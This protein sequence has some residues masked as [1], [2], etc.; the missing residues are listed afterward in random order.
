[1][2][3]RVR[4]LPA[5]FEPEPSDYLIQ[6][7]DHLQRQLGDLAE[8]APAQPVSSLDATGVDAILLADLSGAAYGRAA[9]LVACELPI[10]I[11][12]SEFATVS[13]WDWEIRDYLAHRGVTTIAPDSVQEARL[14]LS[15]LAAKRDLNGGVFL[16]YLDDLGAGMQPDIFK[17]FFW[18][19]DECVE[20]LK[21]QFGLNVIRKSYRGLIAQAQEIPAE[22]VAA[23]AAQVRL[24][25]Q[26]NLSDSQ[27]ED[28]MRIYLALERD[29]TST[30]RV[31]AAGINCLNESESA[32]ST[33]C[34][35]FDLL[36]ERHGIIWGCESDLMSMFTAYVVDKVTD[37]AFAMTN[38]YPFAIGEAALK[39][40]GIPGFPQVAGEP[41]DHIL[42][43]HCGYFGIVPK[44]RACQWSCE[45]PVL[46]IVNRNS[47][48]IDAR[49]QTGQATLVKARGDARR[50]T[51]KRADF[52]DYVQYPG[53]DCRNGGVLRVDD[54]VGYVEKLPSH[55]AIVA[56]G[57]L[58][59]RL[60]L[61]GA[62]MGL[63]I[64][65]L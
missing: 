40:E 53:S 17:R 33:P 62:V 64:E 24:E 28:A 55:H 44:C 20:T 16:A 26:P 21:E 38:L 48:A 14:L 22:R 29:V 1:M 11:I 52:V 42:V 37:A 10:M 59:R 54:G 25:R 31:L 12:T 43:A 9:E 15:G 35:A 61:V 23:A 18:Y 3:E 45:P 47:H 2:S 34:L 58:Q 51:V 4:L 63:S 30:G 7:L 46:A 39:H 41:S 32:T 19:T 5:Y 8:L 60:E 27:L 13:M 36:F 50:L 65:V 49:M 6:Q 56:E 57:D